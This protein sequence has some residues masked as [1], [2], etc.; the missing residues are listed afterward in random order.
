MHNKPSMYDGLFTGKIGSHGMSYSNNNKN[1]LI[2]VAFRAKD[3]IE[4]SEDHYVKVRKLLFAGTAG[5]V[6]LH[7]T[8]G[9][10][11]LHKAGSTNLE[12]PA[13]SADEHLQI[14]NISDANGPKEE[15]LLYGDWSNE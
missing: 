1:H 5:Q 12:L 7:D 11:L 4:I 3:I 6:D 14:L 13:E 8:K 2:M 10:G 9:M 15:E